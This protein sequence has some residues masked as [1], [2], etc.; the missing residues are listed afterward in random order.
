MKLQLAV[1]PEP[2][3]NGQAQPGTSNKLVAQTDAPFVPESSQ[4]QAE[5]M[6]SQPFREGDKLVVPKG[7]SLPPF[8]VKCGRSTVTRVDKSFSWLNPWYYL[9]LFLHLGILLV[10]LIFRKKVKLSVPLCDSHRQYMRR[11]TITATVLLVGCIPVGVLLG[12]LIGEP[13]GDMWGL[14]I[15]ILM[16]FG[17]LIAVLLHRPLQATHID[18]GRA[19]LKGACGAFLPKLTA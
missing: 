17:G 10:Y 5:G 12:S 8:C 11:L 13:D 3:N 19:T 18:N 14:L 16:L 7:A 2:T 4:E 9:L 6:Q 1:V 15:G